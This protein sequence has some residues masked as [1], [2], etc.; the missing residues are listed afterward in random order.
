MCE[1]TH[2][3]SEWGLEGTTI[4]SLGFRLRWKKVAV[5][6]GGFPPLVDSGELLLLPILKNNNW[7]FIFS[8]PKTP[9]PLNPL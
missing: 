3:K 8:F 4:I 5:E 9:P 2:G 6:L 1:A 7:H